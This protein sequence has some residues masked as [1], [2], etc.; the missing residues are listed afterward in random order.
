M[1]RAGKRILIVEDTASIAVLI[2]T[3][4]RRDGLIVDI[5]NTSNKA[6][7]KFITSMDGPIPYDLLLVDLNLP[8]GDGAELLAQMASFD[9]CPS[10]FVVSADGSDSARER[11]KIAGADQFF[12]KPF[13]LSLLKKEIEKK[14]SNLGQ[15]G[16]KKPPETFD[17]AEQT[18]VEN[19]QEYLTKLAWDL[20]SKMSYKSMSSL[21]HQLKG[22]ANLYGY[23]ELSDLASSLGMRLAE[24]GPVYTCDIRE[25]LRQEL[26]VDL[27]SHAKFASCNSGVAV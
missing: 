15:V 7:S 10:S 27:A 12:E 6:L 20:R 24:Q 1:C 18:L 16:P 2:A 14:V 17:D 23:K 8:D 4:L 3:T 11:A 25:V 22:S 5:A 26:V 21:L 9:D 13:N 19:Y